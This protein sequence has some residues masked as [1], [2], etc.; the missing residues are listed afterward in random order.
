MLIESDLLIAYV[1]RVDWLKKVAT[2][3]MS[4]I[5]QGTL[6]PIQAST[7]VF[8]ELYYVL[9][10]F[11]PV[12]TI[13]ADEAKI[14]TIRNITF[15]PPTAETYLASMALMETYGFKSIFDAI[16]AATALSGSVPDHMILSTDVVYDRVKGL[17]R[18]DPM[19]LEL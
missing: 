1:K 15:I 10:E 13:I 5:E 6:S 8:H 4:A 14:S 12:Q 16:H 18:V 7:E 3:V 9:S 11:A 19:A 17:R 2:D